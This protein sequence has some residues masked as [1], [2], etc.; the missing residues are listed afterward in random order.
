MP[1]EGILGLAG[2]F[3]VAGAPRVL[4]S[5]WRVDDEATRALMVRFY[6]LWNPEAGP[7]KGLGAAAALEAA[8]AHVREQE[9]WRHPYFWAGWTLWGAAD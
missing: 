2:A 3:M 8:Q 6:E 5:L 9:R 1:A 7:E 4:V